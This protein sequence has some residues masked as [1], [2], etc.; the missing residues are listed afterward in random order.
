MEISL[1]LGFLGLG[2]GGC[3]IAHACAGVRT[4]I[5]NNMHP[6]TAF[7]VNTNEVD[8]RKLP[9][10]PNAVKYVLRGY[11]R[12][13]GRDIA[14]GEEAFLRHKDDIAKR[15][16]DYFADR[17]FLFIVCG[18]GGG[19]GTGAV[20][21]AVRTV[22]ANG[23]AG[24]FGL[25]LTLPRD[26]EGYQVLDNALQRLQVIARAMK[27]LGSLLIVDNQKLFD[28]YLAENPGGGVAD[29]LDHSN[30][31]IAEML[32]RLNVVTASY[33]PLAG[34]HYDSSELLKTFQT[35]GVL[36]FARCELDET[37]VD[38]EN[39]GSYLPA[40][41]AAIENGVLSDGYDFAE[42]SRCA[43]SLV[44][45]PQGAKRIFT[46]GMVNEVERLL[47]ALAPYAAE[48]PVAVYADEHARKMQVYA[49]FA[50]LGLPKRVA[51]LV[52]AAR[53]YDRPE[54]GNDVLHELGS[55]CSRGRQEAEDLE[56][57]LAGAQP[58]K[59]PADSN[60]PFDFL[61]PVN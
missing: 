46:L 3:S 24:R 29:F 4:A 13:A 22:H 57:L 38:A 17:D 18:L 35:P 32:H 7:L 19:T 48:R 10:R 45:S 51:A 56:A 1:K 53:Q 21:E 31:Y 37:A 49:V 43:V 15:V 28:E 47:T 58:V 26:Q 9:D 16:K 27:G 12:G 8:L 39:R 5:R 41:K 50:G 14:V 25:I 2:M 44:A 36:T 59:R 11:E 60:D 42:A 61:K 40:L 20:I 52:Q 6:Y 55:Y 33:A 34:Y 54:Q 23:F 30:R